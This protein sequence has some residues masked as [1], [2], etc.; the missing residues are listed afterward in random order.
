[1]RD[2]YNLNILDTEDDAGELDI[3]VCCGR[4]SEIL[5][6]GKRT[7]VKKR[8]KMTLNYSLK[9]EISDSQNLAKLG[10]GGKPSLLVL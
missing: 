5:P 3:P 9:L 1:M 6:K 4:L 10:L 7:V 8:P 2:K